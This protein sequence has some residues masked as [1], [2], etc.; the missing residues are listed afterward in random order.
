MIN[1]HIGLALLAMKEMCHNCNNC[2]KCP[3]VDFCRHNDSVLPC[4]WDAKTFPDTIAVL[5]IKKEK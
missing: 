2:L 5:D 4:A 1:I 3:M